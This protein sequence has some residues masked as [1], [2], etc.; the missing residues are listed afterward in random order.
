VSEKIKCSLKEKETSSSLHLTLTLLMFLGL[1]G[2]GVLAGCSGTP[3][4]VITIRLLDEFTSAAVEGGSTDSVPSPPP[5]E[6]RFDGSAS[7]A[8]KQWKAGPG[9]AGLSSTDLQPLSWS[10]RK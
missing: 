4:E 2:L 7:G 6:W 3:S 10:G 8:N 1:L 9:V 5:T